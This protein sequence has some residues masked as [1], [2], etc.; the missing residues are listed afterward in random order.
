MWL[1]EAYLVSYFVLLAP[2]IHLYC[3]Y[4]KMLR[5]NNTITA[6]KYEKNHISKS[7]FRF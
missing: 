6:L 2:N 1:L 7:V 3:S 4:P 5:E